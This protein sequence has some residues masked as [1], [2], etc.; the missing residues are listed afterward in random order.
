M[1]HST[2]IDKSINDSILTYSVMDGASY[3]LSGHGEHVLNNHNLDFY[4]LYFKKHN[5]SN[6][7]PYHNEY[8]TEC[9][10]LNCLEGAYYEGVTGS[11]LRSLLVAALFH[12]FNHTG[13]EMEDGYN[14]H[15]TVK[16]LEYAHYY[17]RESTYH[18]RF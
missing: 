12:D 17:V 2:K 6:S 1:N 5:L 7:L 15:L 3:K 16:G 8:H 9:M 4:H 10:V 14:I 11:Q 18:A 13:G